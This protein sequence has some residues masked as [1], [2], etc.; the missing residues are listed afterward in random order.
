MIL[1]IM[2]CAS[3]GSIILIGICAPLAPLTPA[4]PM[5][6]HA[7]Y[8]IERQIVLPEQYSDQK[9]VKEDEQMRESAIRDT[10]RTAI[11][12]RSV[13]VLQR[14]GMSQEQIKEELSRDFA[15]SAEKLD[16]LLNKAEK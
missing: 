3:I 4:P 14:H 15:I 16:E 6:I 7:P 12:E 5:D 11:V 10:L 8:A 9:N 1:G 13:N 2:L